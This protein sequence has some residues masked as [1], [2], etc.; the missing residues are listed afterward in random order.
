M[1]ADANPPTVARP[2]TLRA[3]PAGARDGA[4][5]ARDGDDSADGAAEGAV[6]GAAEGAARGTAGSAGDAAWTR[7]VAQ[8]VEDLDTLAELLGLDADA[9]RARCAPDPFALR[10]PRSFVRRMRRGDPDDPLLLQVLNRREERD[11]VAGYVADPLAE[12]LASPCPGL[13]HKYAGRVLLTATT[14]CPVHCR[15]CFR[16][17]FPY[18]S[19]RLTRDTLAPALDYIAADPTIREVILS[20]GEPLM[21]RDAP[22]ARL[23]DALEAIPHVELLRIHSRFP[24]VVPRRVTPALV[25]RLAASRCRTTL[26]LHANHAAEIDDEVRGALAPLVSSPVT[27]LNQSVL[28]AGVNDSVGALEALSRAL[29]A[30]GILPYYLHVLDPVAGAAHFATGDARARE[31]RDALI[32]RLPGYLVPTLVREIA[33]RAAKTRL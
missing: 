16:R 29:H 32:D 10:V 19:H 6:E 3:P 24:V 22:L 1:S 12:R 8:A 7:E 5:S 4:R 11:E 31:L 30:A 17:H 27:L 18:E 21:L 33:G 20:G 14:V 13:I 15:Y 26:V 25:E 23:L 9:L 2:V 28:L